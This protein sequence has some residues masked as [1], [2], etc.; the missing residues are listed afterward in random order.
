MQ[1]RQ[2]RIAVL[3]P[4]YTEEAAIGQTVAASSL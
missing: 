1:D 3:L 4:C 2:L